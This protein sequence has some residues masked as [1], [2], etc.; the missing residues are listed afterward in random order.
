MN[1]SGPEP[2]AR[3]DPAPTRVWLRVP[4]DE[5]EADRWVAG[6]YDELRRLARSHLR[7]ER[8][9]HTLGPTALVHE[10]YMRMARHA[11]LANGDRGRFFAV[12]SAT[13]RRVLVDHARRR[14]RHKRNGGELPVALDEVEYLLSSDDAEELVAL[15]GALDRLRE[16]NPRAADVVQHRFFGA[17]TLD[18]TARLLSVSLKTV[19]RDWVVARAWL[20]KEVARDRD[21]SPQSARIA[22]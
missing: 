4:S 17:L 3:S 22:A 21:A 9:G 20:R 15:D 8:T 11:S 13:M 7:R 5:R 12:A 10:A 6:L 16:V 1:P 2:S 19:Q 14:R 18:E